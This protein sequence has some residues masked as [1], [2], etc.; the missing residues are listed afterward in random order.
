MGD[1]EREKAITIRKVPSPVC[2]RTRR[3]KIMGKKDRE[4]EFKF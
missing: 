2:A 3:R 1:E 4:F